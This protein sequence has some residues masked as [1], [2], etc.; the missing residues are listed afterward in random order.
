MPIIYLFAFIFAGLA[1]QLVLG[2]HKWF[3]NGVNLLSKFVYYVLVPVVFFDIF[4]ARGLA[5]ADAG[6]LLTVT[7]YVVVSVAGL[8]IG[9]RGLDDKRRKA[10]TITSTF[11][12]AV[13]LGFPVVMI[14]FGDLTPAAMY[15]LV[16]FIYHL[17]TAG[18]LST[19]KTNI[20]RSVAGIPIIYGFSLGTLLHYTVDPSIVEPLHQLLA[21]THPMLS[22]T[23]VFV[24][25]AS[26]PLNLSVITSSVREVVLIGLWRFIIGPLIHY[27]VMLLIDL[28]PLYEGEIMVLSF[29]P[30][31]VMNTVLARIYGW[32]PEM[33]AGATMIHTFIGLIIILYFAVLGVPF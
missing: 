10:V 8:M 30:P 5:I 7:I 19:G 33:V 4:M 16:M 6:V 9:L 20:A 22:Y 21:P 25:G 31:A 24:L 1:L 2:K 29:M 12:N 14:M 17:V 15:S 18:M 11:Q 27:L 28:P 32:E 23:A 3:H 13:F 26:I